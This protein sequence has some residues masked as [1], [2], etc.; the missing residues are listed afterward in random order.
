MAR[1][2]DWV[3]FWAMLAASL[4][5]AGSYYARYQASHP[6]W[7]TVFPKSGATL[8]ETLASLHAPRAGTN[9]VIIR[10]L[11]IFRTDVDPWREIDLGEIASGRFA[12]SASHSYAVVALLGCT[13]RAGYYH[14]TVFIG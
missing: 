8:E 4:G 3:G 14:P 11:E 13:G 9:I 2:R 5:C 1:R 7:D 10:R 6:G 12:P